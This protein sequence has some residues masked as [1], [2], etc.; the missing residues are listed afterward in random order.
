MKRISHQRFHSNH[1]D[2]HNHASLE[3]HQLE[4]VSANNP[5]GQSERRNISRIPIPIKPPNKM[6]PRTTKEM[7][8]V[9]DIENLDDCKQK[10]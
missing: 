3:I 6:M 1:N 10:R 2:V 8:A 4:M 9:I 5:L 7:E